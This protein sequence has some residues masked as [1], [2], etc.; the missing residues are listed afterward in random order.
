MNTGPG[1]HEQLQHSQGKDDFSIILAGQS[2]TVKNISE[3]NQVQLSAKKEKNENTWPTTKTWKRRSIWQQEG[4]TRS[5]HRDVKNPQE[6]QMNGKDSIRAV[7][8]LSVFIFI[9]DKNQDMGR[10]KEER[11]QETDKSNN[12]AWVTSIQET[13]SKS[14]VLPTGTMS[15]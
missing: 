13:S 9:K 7:A 3:S 14:S 8:S 15:T 12:N 2:S 1:K 4:K 10:R 5:V 6:T 11:A